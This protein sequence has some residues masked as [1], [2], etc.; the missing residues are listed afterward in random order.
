VAPFIGSMRLDAANVY[1]AAL[2]LVASVSFVVVFV[3]RAWAWSRPALAGRTANHGA[4]DPLPR[5]GARSAGDDLR[6]AETPA[7]MLT[8]MRVDEVTVSRIRH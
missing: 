5:H 1:I 4:A 3:P 8:H 7:C 6:P 2:W